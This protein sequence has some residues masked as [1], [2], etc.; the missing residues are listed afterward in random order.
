MVLP[1]HGP[2]MRPAGGGG[3]CDELLEAG[4]TNCWRWVWPK[5]LSAALFCTRRLDVEGTEYDGTVKAAVLSAPY[6]AT[7]GS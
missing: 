7:T 1:R 5:E 3:G 6:Q 4:V 2:A